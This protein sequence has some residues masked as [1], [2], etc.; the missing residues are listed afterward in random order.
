MRSGP[1]TILMATVLFIS[2]LSFTSP[3]LAAEDDDCPGINGDSTNDRN[4]CPD[5]DGDGWSDPDE[6][7]STADGADA[8]PNEKT[9]WADRDGDGFGD[10][11]SFDAVLIDHFPD[12]ENLHRAVLSVGCNPPDHTLPIGKSSY[13]LCTVKNEGLVP[14]RLTAEWDAKKGISISELPTKIDLEEHGLGGD[15]SELRLDF[16]AESAGVSGG[17]LYF[18][19]SSDPEPIFSVALGV[20]VETSTPQAS[21]SDATPTLDPLR[22]KANSV[23][24]WMSAKTGYNF[25]LQT[26]LA[27]LIIGPFILFVIGRKTQS[28]LHNRKL[29]RESLEK[30]STNEEEREKEVEPEPK[31]LSLEDMATDPNVTETKPKRGVKG[32]EGRILADGMVEVMVGEINMPASPDDAFNVLNENLDESE[33]EGDSWDSSLDEQEDDDTD[34]KVAPK[35]RTSKAQTDELVEEEPKIVTRKGQ[36]VTAKQAKSVAKE[37]ASIDAKIDSKS[38]KK[39]KK[40]GKKRPPGKVG[41]TRGPGVDLK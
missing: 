33:I 8:F 2:L 27:L 14:I 13:F 36:K 31:E 23:A 4:G 19:E 3:A 11:N 38:K 16:T 7:W 20:L 21:S 1:V 34:F 10:T 40:S 15:Q 29:E 39:Q 17:L 5:T 26:V 18:N 22:D 28:S 37:K 9:Q 12:D 30:E 6:D 25:N 24:S 35:H 32:A 41:H